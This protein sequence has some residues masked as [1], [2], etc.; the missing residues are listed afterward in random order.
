M[1]CRIHRQMHSALGPLH[2]ACFSQATTSASLRTC[3]CQSCKIFAVGSLVFEGLANMRG[4]AIQ[5]LW[6]TIASTWF[7][8][9]ALCDSNQFGDKQWRSGKQKWHTHIEW[10]YVGFI[11]SS[12]LTILQRSEEPI[13]SSN[14]EW[15]KPCFRQN[16]SYHRLCCT[17][18]PSKV[19]NIRST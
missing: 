19:Q 5:R 18:P 2:S 8:Q 11:I 7:E 14:C 4:S 10:R 9:C 17:A 13:E 1:E 12:V 15:T 3:S 6:N 16:T